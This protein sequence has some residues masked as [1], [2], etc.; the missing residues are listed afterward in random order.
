[1]AAGRAF[2]S[3]HFPVKNLPRDDLTGK[4]GYGYGGGRQYCGSS[5]TGHSYCD[6]GSS[7]LGGIT[8]AG[9]TQSHRETYNGWDY[10]VGKISTSGFFSMFFYVI[11]TSRVTYPLRIDR[12]QRINQFL[13]KLANDNHLKF[14]NYQPNFALLKHQASIH[15][16]WPQ[17]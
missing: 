1:M 7:I 8:T 16:R 13:S 4:E 11:F 17:C 5:G 10:I 14:L 9:L 15:E 12:V 2:I 3:S 6:T